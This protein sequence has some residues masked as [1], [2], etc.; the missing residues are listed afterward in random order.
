MKDLSITINLSFVFGCQI[1]PISS[2]ASHT[3]GL[4]IRTVK[5]T[6]M[7][8]K[9]LVYQQLSYALVVWSPYSSD[10]VNSFN[11]YR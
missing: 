10:M 5:H 6:V 7:L 9:I 3:L 4:T 8:L 11:R 1:N 2:K